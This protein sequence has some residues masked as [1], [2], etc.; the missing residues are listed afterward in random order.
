M[1]DMEIR[2]GSEEELD[3]Q[4]GRLKTALDQIS[5]HK[6]SVRYIDVRFQEPVVSPRT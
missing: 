1:D 2:C 4:L 6:I 5:R 3:E